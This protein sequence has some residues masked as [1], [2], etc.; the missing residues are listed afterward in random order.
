LSAL[1]VIHVSAYVNPRLVAEINKKNP[2]WIAGENLVWQGKSLEEIKTSFGYRKDLEKPLSGKPS[3]DYA[4]ALPTSFSAEV[5]WPACR[6]I[7][8]IYN[9]ARCGS[10][11][12]FG[13]VETAADRFCIASKGKF[14]EAL[15]FAQ[16]TE[17]DTDANGCE[18][19][20]TYAVWSFLGN[21][22]VV[23]NKCY[24]YFI[25]TCPPAKQPCLDFV[26]TPD[27]WTNNTCNNGQ[28]WKSY[29]M[30]NTYNLNSVEDMQRDIMTKGPVEAC[31][32]V[33]EDFLQYKSGVYA[34]TT[35]GYLGGHCVKILGWGVENGK[36]YWL[37]NNQWTTYWGDKGQFKIAL[38][39]NECGI[40]DNVAA[41]DPKL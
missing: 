18:G 34:H 27:C 29:Q 22:G 11:W 6:T 14:N 33:Y 16:V 2:G 35:G 15:S 40:E 1:F 5:A 25:P 31:F 32:S 20:S 26:D 30:S 3:V 37:V 21:T 38:G 8:T 23:T 9:Q 36:P 39:N 28:P 41:G 10:C 24:P 7:G 19:G 4:A 12:A 13:G 17:C